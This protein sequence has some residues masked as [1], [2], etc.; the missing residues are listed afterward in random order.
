MLC[1][2]LRFECPLKAEV[3]GSNPVGAT[4]KYEVRGINALTFF[5][6]W[7]PFSGKLAKNWL[8]MC[9]LDV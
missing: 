1:S 7:G 8:R 2:V 6:R 5:F 9:S 3:A 4:R